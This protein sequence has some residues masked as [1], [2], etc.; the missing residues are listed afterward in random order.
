MW[1]SV[2]QPSDADKIVIF[3]HSK[4]ARMKVSA[5]NGHGTHNHTIFNA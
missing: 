1:G 3:Q 5:N 2:A 4:Y